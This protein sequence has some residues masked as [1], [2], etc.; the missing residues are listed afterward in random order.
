MY[1]FFKK[2]VQ[3][4]RDLKGMKSH[5]FHVMM[6]DILPLCL[7]VL[8]S[9]GCRMSIHYDKIVSIATCPLGLKSA[10]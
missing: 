6:Q 8:M 7:Q 4:D 9:K 10:Q 5:D 2:K 1:I 3:K